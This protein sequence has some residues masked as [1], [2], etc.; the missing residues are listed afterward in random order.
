MNKTFIELLAFT[1]ALLLAQVL[2]FNHVCLFGVGV[3]FVFLFVLLR[4]PVTLSREWCYTI[5]FLIGLTIDVCSD[6]LGMNALS[7]TLLM[8]LRRPVLRLYVLRDEEITNPCPGSA[9]LGFFTYVK[10]ATTM[11]LIYCIFIFTIEAF[12][13]L[14][15]V[16]LI[17]RIV[18]STVLTSLLL[19]GIDSL[20]VSHREKRL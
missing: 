10:Y 19:I 1:L 20:T 7:C 5:A 15:P 4:L 2:V 11:S 17:L 18:A 6:T 13:F 16:Q 8:A 9:S 12:T 14:N 3:P